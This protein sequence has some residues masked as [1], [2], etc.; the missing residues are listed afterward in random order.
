LLISP[1]CGGEGW[2]RRGVGSMAGFGAGYLR[3]AGLAI[4]L[5]K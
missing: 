3:P 2:N 4:G 5:V 1:V